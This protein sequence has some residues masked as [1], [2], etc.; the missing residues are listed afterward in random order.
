VGLQDVQDRSTT[1]AVILLARKRHKP[2]LSC[3]GT[4]RALRVYRR[5]FG[6]GIVVPVV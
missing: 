1:A 6:T 4:L 3:C 5:L 2:L